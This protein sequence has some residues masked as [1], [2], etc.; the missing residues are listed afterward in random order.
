MRSKRLSVGMR[1]TVAIFM[2]TLFGTCTCA[3]GQEILHSFSGNHTDGS[4]PYGGLVSDALGNLYG[5]TAHG[6]AY[7]LGTVF[8]LE[9]SAGGSW[10]ETLLYSFGTHSA[11]GAEPYASLIFDASGNLYGTTTAGGGPSNQGTVFELTPVSSGGWTESVLYIFGGT[12]MDGIEPNGSVIFDASGNLYGT[13][14]SG[15]NPGGFGTVFELSPTG[16]GNWTETVLYYFG[17]TSTDAI[18]PYASLI[19]DAS[20]NLY[21]TTSAGGPYTNDR[22]ISGGTVFE[23]SPTGG[24]LWSET[25]LHGFGDNTDGLAPYSTL[26]FDAFGNLYGTTLQ[27]GTQNGGTAFELTP[28]AGG[29]WTET[30]LLSFGNNHTSGIYPRAGLV[31]DAHGNLYGTT[32][33]GG[34]GNVHQY[35][36]VVFELKPRAGGG[37][38]EKVLDIFVNNHLGGYTPYAGLI[39]NPSGNLC[40]TTETGGVHE[41]GTVFVIKP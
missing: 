41:R 27:G 30:I 40:G 17:A 34:G 20:G 1:A 18:R 11:D 19:F 22:G 3:A 14:A 25:I 5:T 4:Y 26:I 12:S 23:L 29:S 37:W 7:H 6:G 21:G 32:G 8:E 2:V 24:G 13:T 9:H 31:F 39:F 15:G 36:G 38:T 10:T 35:S 33:N 28:S 16:G